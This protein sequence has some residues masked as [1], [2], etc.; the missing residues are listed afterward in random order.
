MQSSVLAQ[1]DCETSYSVPAFLV[2]FIVLNFSA[3][4]TETDS[5]SMQNN[6]KSN[7]FAT[8]RRQQIKKSWQDPMCVLSDVKCLIRILQRM[9]A[10]SN[11]ITTTTTIQHSHPNEGNK[12]LH[13]NLNDHEATNHDNIHKHSHKWRE[14]VH[15][16]VNNHQGWKTIWNRCCVDVHR[17]S[18]MA[19]AMASGIGVYTCESRQEVYVLYFVHNTV[20]RFRDASHL[21]HKHNPVM[22]YGIHVYTPSCHIKHVRLKVTSFLQRETVGVMRHTSCVGTHGRIHCETW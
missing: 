11:T 19:C 9:I 16:H 10:Q 14:T 13:L 22:F 20:R 8:T 17:Y 2:W 7:K 12:S 4:L 15:L 5:C 18:G 1:W 21:C 6:N 3:L